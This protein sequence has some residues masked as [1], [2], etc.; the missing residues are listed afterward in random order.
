MWLDGPDATQA[1]GVR[2]GA[3]ARAGDVVALEG[4]LGAGKTCLAQGIA[5]GVEVP[6]GHYVNSPTFTIAQ[7]HPGRVRL[8]HI[9][10]Y[11]IDDPD[12]LWG[13]GIDELIGTDGLAVIEWPSRVPDALPRDTLWI[14]LATERGGR[15]ITWW[16]RGP[17][18]QRLAAALEPTPSV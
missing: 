4:P 13:A 14:Y 16:A 2:L 7:V 18:S 9:D 17:R 15:R 1:V 8:Y 12:E 10:L 6:A 5:R 11:R 3:M